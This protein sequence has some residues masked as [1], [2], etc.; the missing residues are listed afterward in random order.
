M[1][2]RAQQFLDRAI[3]AFMASDVVKEIR[4]SN[5]TMSADAT[6]LEQATIHQF[7]QVWTADIQHLCGFRWAQL[8]ILGQHGDALTTHHCVHEILQHYGDR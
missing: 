1:F 8:S 3:G 5:S 6:K 7:G 2:T 4:H